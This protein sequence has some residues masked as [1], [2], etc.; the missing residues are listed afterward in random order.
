MRI[1]VIDR[2]I[3][4]GHCHTHTAR[5][6]FTGWG[7]HIVTVRGGTVA[8]DFS[9]DFR[10]T[11]LGVL[12]LFDH[13]HATTA[14]NDKTVPVGVIGPGGLFRSI[15]VLGAQGAHG[16]EQPGLS[17]VLFFTATGKHDVLFA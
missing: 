2:A 5:R 7:N 11:G 9:V 4:A 13:D 10:P 16:V 15:V 1:D 6:A 12:Q 3:G 14:G 8:G 17:P